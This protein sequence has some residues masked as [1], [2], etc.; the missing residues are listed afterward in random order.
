[1]IDA[2]RKRQRR[3]TDPADL[4]TLA[5]AGF[6]GDVEEE[7]LGRLG[8]AAARALVEALPAAQAEV[9]A[10]RVLADLSVEETARV[11]GRRPGAV[12]TLQHRALRRLAAQ[13]GDEA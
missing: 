5:Q 9:I 2:G 13:L 4:A 12:R 11:M 8:G 10:L 3:R 1:M 7:A 6:D